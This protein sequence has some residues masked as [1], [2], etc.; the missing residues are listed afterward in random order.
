[1]GGL[2]VVLTHSATH[3][4]DPKKLRAIAPTHVDA[5]EWNSWKKKGDPVLHIELAKWADVFV[6][7][8]LSAHT[9]AKLAGGFSSGLLCSTARA[10]DPKK[11][12]IIAPA[13]NTQ[14]WNHPLTRMHLDILK[15]LKYQELEPD[16]KTLACGDTGIGAM[17]SI[18]KIAQATKDTIWGKIPRN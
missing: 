9:L 10:W 15:K 1:M 16:I 18:S 12:I 11:P 7:A 14:M 17:T 13:M 4:C 2:Q 8:P 5:D 3:F 6:I